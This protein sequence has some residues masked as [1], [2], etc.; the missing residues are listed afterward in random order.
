M[1]S[2]KRKKKKKKKATPPVGRGRARRD[3]ER[4]EESYGENRLGGG[5]RKG[6][7]KEKKK[8]KRIDEALPP[9]LYTFGRREKGRFG[10]QRWTAPGFLRSVAEGKKKKGEATPKIQFF[11]FFNMQTEG[12]EVTTIN[13]LSRVAA[14][15][16]SQTKG[17]KKRKGPR[18][19]ESHPSAY[20]RACDKERRG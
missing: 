19:P 20:S 3:G 14:Q 12:K 2:R 16:P 15:R 6:E 8:R 10:N 4:E 5:K 9:Y 18:E 13:D 7:K 11:F 1:T 17:G